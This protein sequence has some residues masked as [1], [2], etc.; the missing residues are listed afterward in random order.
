MANDPEYLKPRP[1]NF[2]PLSP[3][4]F[5]NRTAEVYPNRLALIDDDRRF[6]WAEVYQRCTRLAAA[7][8][9]H[10]VKPGD[11]VS[12]L[13]PNTAEMFEA[14]FGVAM[15]GAVLNTINVRLD[16]DTVAYILD[17][18]DTKVLMIDRQFAPLATAALA[19]LP[20]PQP[21]LIDCGG[22]GDPIPGATAHATLI[23]QT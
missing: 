22:P 23:T 15:A 4:S 6:T 12:I 14:H 21:L 17:H 3:L 11:V 13:A 16:V 8:Q 5:L 2:V 9:S 10:G 7:L 20:S 1:A 18:A 19:R